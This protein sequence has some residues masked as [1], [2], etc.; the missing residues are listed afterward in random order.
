MKV[1]FD[2]WA[3]LTAMHAREVCNYVAELHGRI[4]MLENL[5]AYELMPEDC[6]DEANTSVVV[7]ILER[8]KGPDQH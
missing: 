6:A 5:I 3:E 4:T 1:T 2:E 7:A 8:R